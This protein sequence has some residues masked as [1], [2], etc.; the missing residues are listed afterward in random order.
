MAWKITT[1][2]IDDTSIRLM[3]IRGKRISKL[4]E[5]SLDRGLDDLNAQD[6]QAELAAKIKH[7]LKTHKVN[8]KKVVVGVS[9]LR[10][11]SRP[12]VLPYLPK[13]MLDEAMIREAKRVLP[14]PPEQLHISWQVLSTSQGKM[15][16]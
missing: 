5:A 6:A 12:T 11:L 10:C 1:L 16:A 2:Y 14:V 9:G 3:V 13:T 8:E 15:Q 4:A 7:L